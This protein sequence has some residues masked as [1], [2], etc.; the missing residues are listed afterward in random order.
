MLA[1]LKLTRP[2]N[3][4]II[5]LTMYL[6]REFVLRPIVSYNQFELQLSHWQFFILVLSTV[7][8]A[9]AGNIINDYF[10]Q[11][12]DRVNRPKEIIVGV[13]VK[14]R[15]AMIVH[16]LLN[17]IGL[18]LALYLALS[19]DFWKLAIISFFAAGSLWYYSTLFKKELLIGNIMIALL[20]GLVPLLVGVYEIPLLAR[21][22]GAE[23][24]QAFKLHRP[25]ED[26]ADY[27]KI[28][29]YFILGYA[30]FAF[31]LNLVR[32][33][34]KDMADVEGDKRVGCHTIPIQYGIR[35]AK[36]VSN[37]LIAMT[38]ISLVILQQ[39]VVSDTY[40]LLYMS[41]FII[42]PLLISMYVS[43]KAKIRS[44]FVRAGNYL[45]L[46]MLFGVLYSILHAYLY[47]GYTII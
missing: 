47:Y 4:F 32:E 19:I 16:Q 3:L 2:L 9:A 39:K 13:K 41:L 18:G 37:V 24:V 14:R 43:L 42:V 35:T 40:S 6:M 31:L 29:F 36:W 8:I 23:V 15:V 7:L 28:M 34:Q 45:K 26:P 21:V 10:D 20:A 22:Y 38:I 5:A 11:R 27:F 30:L 12:T 33:I 17:L 44:Q 1:L 46:A 25:G